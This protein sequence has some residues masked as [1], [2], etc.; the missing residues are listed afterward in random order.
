MS[1]K[2]SVRVV[3]TIIMKV[4]PLTRLRLST[5]YLPIILSFRQACDQSF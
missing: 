5:M 4:V 2:S 3:M 1:M